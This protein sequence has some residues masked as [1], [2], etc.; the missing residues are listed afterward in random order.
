MTA[1]RPKWN[2]KESGPAAPGRAAAKKRLRMLFK[3]SSSGIVT[4]FCGYEGMIK[5][6]SKVAA[7]LHK[8]TIGA[9]TRKKV[10]MRRSFS[11]QRRFMANLGGQAGDTGYLEGAGFGFTVSDTKKPVEKFI[12]HKGI[13]QKGKLKSAMRRS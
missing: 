5:A 11:Q 1:L 8:R 4:E 6:Q 10:K 13:V 12:V 2:S 3:A 9:K 7:I